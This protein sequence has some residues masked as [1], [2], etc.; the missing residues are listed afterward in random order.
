V[1]TT[2]VVNGK[3]VD[4]KI[5]FILLAFTAGI[6][7]VGDKFTT[8]DNSIYRLCLCHWWYG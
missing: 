4:L 2:P 3:I 6:N 8:G 5:Y 7:D 1:S